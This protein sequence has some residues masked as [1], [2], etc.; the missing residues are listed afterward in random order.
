MLTFMD[1]DRLVCACGI[2]GLFFPE[3]KKSNLKILLRYILRQFNFDAAE[4]SDDEGFSW[5]PKLLD[6][7]ELI[8]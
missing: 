8:H 3:Q 1:V 2:L 6:H 7:L 5:Y 4:G